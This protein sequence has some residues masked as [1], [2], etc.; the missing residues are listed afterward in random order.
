MS[1]ATWE[2]YIT[3]GKVHEAIDIKILIHGEKEIII[4]AT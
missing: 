1:G 2:V 3:E 4:Y